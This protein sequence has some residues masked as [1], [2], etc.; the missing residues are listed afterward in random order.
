MF[1]FGHPL[2]STQTNHHPKLVIEF[3]ASQVWIKKEVDEEEEDRESEEEEIEGKAGDSSG[4]DA[5]SV[6]G[7]SE[8]EVDDA[9]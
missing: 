6:S 1:T 9:Q 5:V 2:L 7:C 4:M 3:Q 8:G